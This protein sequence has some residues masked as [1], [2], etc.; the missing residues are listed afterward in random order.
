[1]GPDI[2]KFENEIAKI[3]P[4]KFA[5][6]TATIT[7]SAGSSLALKTLGLGKS[8]KIVVP[9]FYIRSLNKCN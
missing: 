6:F 9:D 5:K 8:D 2:K 3:K 1:M 7:G 4:S